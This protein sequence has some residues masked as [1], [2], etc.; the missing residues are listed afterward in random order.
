MPLLLLIQLLVCVAACESSPA[1]AQDTYFYEYRIPEETGDGWETASQPDVGLSESP[2]V[3]LMEDL[4]DMEGHEVHSILVARDG[5][6]VFEEYFDGLEFNLAQYTGGTGFDRDNTHNLASV[7][8]SF[9]TTLAGIAIDQGYIDSVHESVF[10]FFPEHE[11]ILLEDPRRGD[12]T[13]E[14][15][16]LMMSGISWNDIGT[17]SYDDPRNDLV[18]MFNS[19][20]PIRYALSR[21]LYAHPG[22]SSITAT[23]TRTSSARL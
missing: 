20:D 3:R 10:D 22:T 11:D 1:P 19:G 8:K 14:D 7:T 13:L 12:M 21:D 17:C 4:H 15:L 23:R 6:L 2:F 5:K 18:Q 9:T 16:L